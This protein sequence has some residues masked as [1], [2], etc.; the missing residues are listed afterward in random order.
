MR[1]LAV[2]ILL[3]MCSSSWAATVKSIKGK[4][5]LIE[6]MGQNAQPGQMF[7]L[8][9]YEG[10]KKAVVRIRQVKDDRAVAE[11]LKGHAL[12]SYML[13]EEPGGGKSPVQKEERHSTRSKYDAADE[14]TG[15]TWGV[16][17]TYLSSLMSVDFVPSVGVQAST[18]MS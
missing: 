8:L 9:D 5:M 10:R 12:V 13:S 6:L 18:N 4:R 14:Y 17:F 7:F 2:L 15:E 11:L 3:A 16:M 1:V